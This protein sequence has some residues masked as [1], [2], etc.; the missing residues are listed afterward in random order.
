MPNSQ[1]PCRWR[2]LK[3]LPWPRSNLFK[4]AKAEI[5]ARA[6]EIS[7]LPY[8]DMKIQR[9]MYALEFV[10]NNK[11]WTPQ[12]R[13]V[14]TRGCISSMMFCTT[15]HENRLSKARA[16]QETGES[17]VV[18]ESS[19]SNQPTPPA[20]PNDDHGDNSHDGNQEDND[21]KD[22][23]HGD[24]NHEDSNYEDNSQTNHEIPAIAD[25]APCRTRSTRLVVVDLD[26][27]DDNDDE[28]DDLAEARTIDD[29]LSPEALKQ[30]NIR[31]NR[32]VDGNLQTTKSVLLWPLRQ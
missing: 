6:I 16:A 29:K 20:I 17:S 2:T 15:R 30:Y 21:H 25:N 19:D 14:W 31:L 27:D 3:P 5:Q 7:K 4:I 32:F 22:N 8:K 11:D 1:V 12:D 13:Q 24:S 10:S 26:D 28:D 23:D 9:D 18:D